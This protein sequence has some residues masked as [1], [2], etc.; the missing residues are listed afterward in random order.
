MQRC[1]WQI[2]KAHRALQC[3]TSQVAGFLSGDVSYRCLNRHSICSW[4][5]GAQHA[6]PFP[7]GYVQRR[8]ASNVPPPQTSLEARIAAIPLD[9]YRNFCIVAHVDHGKS[10]LSDR[11]LECTGTIPLGGMSQVLDKLAVERERGITVKAQTVTMLYQSGCPTP[12]ADKDLI[13]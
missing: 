4:S 13:I 11:L 5:F 7:F 10:T 8:F 9:R 12:Y 3:T 6:P 2:S 1:L